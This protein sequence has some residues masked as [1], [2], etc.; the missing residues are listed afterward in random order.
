MNKANRPN[1]NTD[2]RRTDLN[3]YSIVVRNARKYTD[4]LDTYI[5]NV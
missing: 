5:V 2:N 4:L 1:I 3:G